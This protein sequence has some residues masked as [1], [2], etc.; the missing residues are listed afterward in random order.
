MPGRYFIL[1]LT[2]FLHMKRTHFSEKQDNNTKNIKQTQTK[3]KDKN[4][5]SSNGRCIILFL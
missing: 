5:R 1:N 3:Y 4:H 2:L